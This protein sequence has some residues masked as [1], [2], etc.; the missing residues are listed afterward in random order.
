MDE[1]VNRF[2]DELI[3]AITAAIG[4]DS[5]VLACQRR[6][7]EA[8][9]DLRL[10]LEAKAVPLESC[11]AAAAGVAS[12]RRSGAVSRGYVITAADRRFLR[13]LRISVEGPEAPDFP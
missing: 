8:G 7:R 9:L 2:T 13:S 12:P 6:A 3:D 10:N 1:A 11:Q 5:K 4:R